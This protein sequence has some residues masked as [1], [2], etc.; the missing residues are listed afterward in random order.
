MCIVLVEQ[1]GPDVWARWDRKKLICE[2]WNWWYTNV[3]RRSLFSR[4]LIRLIRVNCNGCWKTEGTTYQKPLLPL[5]ELSKRKLMRLMEIISRRSILIS[6]LQRLSLI[7]D[8]Q[9]RRCQCSYGLVELHTFGQAVFH[10][11]PCRGELRGFRRRVMHQR[12]PI[13]SYSLTSKCNYELM[14]VWESYYLPS[15]PDRARSWQF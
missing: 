12:H 2:K 10:F 6:R 1:E 15:T 7:R 13:L 11:V 9:Y 14:T 5:V 3:N 8:T 4:N